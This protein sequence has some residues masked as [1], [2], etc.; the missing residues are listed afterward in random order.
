MVIVT[1]AIIDPTQV[2][3]NGTVTVKV[4]VRETVNEPIAYRLAFRLG[5]PHGLNPGGALSRL[6]Q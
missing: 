3:A 1:E 6:S 2:K 5:M 4:K